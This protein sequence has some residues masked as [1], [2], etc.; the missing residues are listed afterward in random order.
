[1][2][3]PKKNL[4]TLSVYAARTAVEAGLIQSLLRS[5]GITVAM[6]EHESRAY[7]GLF[8]VRRGYA[9]VCVFE[10]DVD[11]AKKLI[12]DFLERR[13][14]SSQEGGGQR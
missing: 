10:P 9:D 13:D 11:R 12:A 2:D 5:A 1:M 4:R 3:E 8:L 14:G 7:D 6:E